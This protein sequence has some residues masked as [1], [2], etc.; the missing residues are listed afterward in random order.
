[1]DP[2]A[3]EKE[4]D[5]MSFKPDMDLNQLKDRDGDVAAFI[6]KDAQTGKEYIVPIRDHAKLAALLR[7]MPDGVVATAESALDSI[8]EDIDRA[9][10]IV[11][12][13]GRLRLIKQAIADPEKMIKL[14]QMIASAPPNFK[15]RLS[16]EIRELQG[17]IV[18]REKEQAGEVVTFTGPEGEGQ[19]TMAHLVPGDGK[20]H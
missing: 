18:L 20:V 12:R 11:S 7:S 4:S 10:S 2:L 6:I 15:E 17:E 1:M 3:E 9:I 14:Q 5:H 13:E 16:A 19:F 8:H